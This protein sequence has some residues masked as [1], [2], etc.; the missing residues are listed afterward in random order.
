MARAPNKSLSQRNTWMHPPL[1]RCSH[2]PC[3]SGFS[4]TISPGKCVYLLFKWTRPLRCLSHVHVWPYSLSQSEE[5]CFLLSP[6]TNC[7]MRPQEIK[8]HSWL[9][10][11][12][13]PQCP[14]GNGVKSVGHCARVNNNNNTYDN[15]ITKHTL[16]I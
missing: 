6:W 10:L 11:Y 4:E 15:K 16:Q 12:P 13:A 9:W 7:P 8:D 14:P 5:C 1:L 3:Q 2:F